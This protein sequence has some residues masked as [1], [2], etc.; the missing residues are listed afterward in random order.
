MLIVLPVSIY[1][2]CSLFFELFKN[3]LNPALL[4]YLYLNAS[5]MVFVCV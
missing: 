5:P 1:F 3:K 4:L 2:L